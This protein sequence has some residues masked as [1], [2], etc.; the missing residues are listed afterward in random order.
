MTLH[1]SLQ[2]FLQQLSAERNMAPGTVDAYRYELER[3]E[4]SLAESDP[5][6]VR[7]VAKVDPFDLKDYLARM[8][9]D[10][11]CKAATIARVI[12]SMRQFFGFLLAE[13]I[14][15]NDPA[16]GLRTPKKSRKLPVYLTATEANRMAVPPPIDDGD[17]AGDQLRDETIISLLMLTGMRLSELVG[18]DL[19]SLDL[20]NAV[21]K[22]F[23]KGRKER[24]IPLNSSAR[25]LLRDWLVVRPTGKNGCRALFLSGHRD[26]ITKRMVQHLVK[27]AVKR[28][29]LDRRISPHKLRHTFATT[30][31]AEAVELR[32][33]QEL[34]GHASVVSTAVY[35]HTNV[36]K[37]RAAV[38]KLRMRD[39]E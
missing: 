27:K 24:L 30:L 37:V 15:G 11:N 38:N 17:D 4:K 10:R 1:D 26:R 21:V 13:G 8:K 20:E 7:N 14:I 23:G 25:E 2:K 32:D 5:A 6:K 12:S 29:G 33:I 22:V 35:T 18:L 16:M 36:D 28:N 34:L 9:E 19:D 31:Y 3:L 39:G